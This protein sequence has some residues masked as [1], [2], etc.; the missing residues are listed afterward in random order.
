MRKVTGFPTI[1]G[2]TSGSFG[3]QTSR[4]KKVAKKM[5]SSM[6]VTNKNV[7][8]GLNRPT[9]VPGLPDKGRF[10]R[11]PKFGTPPEFTPVPG[12][13]D[14]GRFPRPPKFGNADV[15]NK[16]KRKVASKMLKRF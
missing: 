12:L 14:K 16:R 8:R 4:R 6:P 15:I 3:G 10:P 13:P 7:D 5:V 1:G 9:P 2:N 11:P